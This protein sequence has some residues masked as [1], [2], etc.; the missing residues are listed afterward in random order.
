MLQQLL[1]EVD[2]GGTLETGALAVRLGTTPQL[3]TAMLEH[4]ERLGM[5]LSYIHCEDGC[6]GC[7][8]RGN[9]SSQ[10]DVRLWQAGKKQ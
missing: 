6:T 10:A 4:L 8:L 2:G 1:A 9:C 5:V 7:S 3:V